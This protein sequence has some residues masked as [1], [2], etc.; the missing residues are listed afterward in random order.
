M[1]KNDE[2]FKKCRLILRLFKY[3]RPFRKTLILIFALSIFATLVSLVPTY[4]MKPLT[5]EVLAPSV[6]KSINERIFSLNGLIILLVIAY[7]LETVIS[8]FLQYKK[9]WL[10]V[11]IGINLRKTLYSHMQKLSLKFYNSEK[12]GSLHSRVC[13]DTRCMELF[14]V[15]DLL[16]FFKSFVM[17]LAIG[18][19]LF[20]LN[21]TLTVLLLLPL[22]I[23]MYLS[24]TFGERL[25]STYRRLYQK[26]ANMSSVVFH[27][28]KGILVVKTSVAEE[29]EIARFDII[30]SN[31][32][33]ERINKSKLYYLFLPA[34]G[35]VLFISGIMIRWFGGWQIITGS[36]SLGTL[37]V[38][39]GYMWQFYNPIRQINGIYAR[40]QDVIAASERYFK[41]LDTDPEIYVKREAITLPYLKGY[42]RFDNIVFSYDGKN[43]VLENINLETQPGEII[44]IIGPSGAGKSSLLQLL[45]RLYEPR[46]GT[47]YIDGQEIRKFDLEFL[48]YQI[49]IVLQDTFLFSGTI[50]ENIGYTK[51]DASKIEIVTAAKAAGAHEFII[52]LPD[53]YD[54]LLGEGGC[55]L[56]GGEKQ[57]IS[58]A[59]VLLKN[60]KI[61]IFDEASS[62][63]DLLTQSIIRR[64]FKKLKEEGHTV[65]IISHQL[66]M[67][68]LTD[69]LIFLDK[70]R[71]AEQ[72]TYESL[73]KAGGALANFLKKKELAQKEERNLD[74]YVL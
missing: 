68:E 36:L 59:R 48:R 43:N 16:D 24:H 4:I 49:G 51:P 40:F 65:F 47:I 55:G 46:S 17:F 37:M 11:K 60:S 35:S 52:N 67:M 64:T 1:K 69:R 21:S 25:V 54:T 28:I 73:S 29:R 26:A 62:S 61:V 72:G 74:F 27:A 63:I 18:V 50:A 22:P 19:V 2:R 7:V 38:F 30:N 8:S 70:G 20:S 57:R 12:T 3:V 56:S 15:N 23:V 13:Y 58:I 32:S 9:D 39:I 14:V 31:V 33:D 6:P 53:A 66:S 45:C 44:G 42:I 41:I 34:M 5:D 71:L 10:G